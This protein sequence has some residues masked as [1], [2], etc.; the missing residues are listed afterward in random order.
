MRKSIIILWIATLLVVI[1]LILSQRY[2]ISGGYRLDRL[3]GKVWILS[4]NT[5][6]LLPVQKTNNELVKKDQSAVKSASSFSKGL[7]EE[8]PKAPFRETK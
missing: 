8:K 5:Q 7:V 2:E 3:T 1:F 4:Y 6:K